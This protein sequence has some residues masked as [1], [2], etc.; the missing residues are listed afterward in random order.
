MEAGQGAVAF[1][2]AAEAP[3][4]TGAGSGRL[5]NSCCK[6]LVCRHAHLG[7]NRYVWTDHRHLGLPQRQAGSKMH[8][9]EASGVAMEQESLVGVQLKAQILLVQVMRWWRQHRKTPSES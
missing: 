6:H 3:E 9:A 8:A 4:N 5:V 7:T 2:Q 1:S